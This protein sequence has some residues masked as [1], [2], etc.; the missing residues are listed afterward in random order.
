MGLASSK[1]ARLICRDVPVPVD[2]SM[3]FCGVSSVTPHTIPTQLELRYGGVGPIPVHRELNPL[4]D[5]PFR[6]KNIEKKLDI[7]N[8]FDS[9]GK[10]RAQ[11]V[12]SL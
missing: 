7:Q 8:I 12:V 9:M 1:P 10:D 6:A 4:H 2:R 3:D 5:H 11:K